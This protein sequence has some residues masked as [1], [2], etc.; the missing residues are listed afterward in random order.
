MKRRQIIDYIHDWVKVYIKNLNSFLPKKLPLIYLF[1]TA[2]GRCRKLY[3]FQTIYQS[4]SKMLYHCEN[5]PNKPILLLFA[6]TGVADV[7][8][9]GI[10]I[11]S[12]TRIP[13]RNKSYLKVPG[14]KS[15]RFSAGYSE[16]VIKEKIRK[17]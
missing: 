12:G 6:G 17:F 15:F 10:T 2:E 13:F 9:Q 1:L 7:N 16:Y 5:G 11:H 14:D 8:T 4:A 3:F